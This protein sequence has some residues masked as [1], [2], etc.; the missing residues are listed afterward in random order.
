M[1]T[2]FAARLLALSIVSTGLAAAPNE[3]PQDRWNLADLYPTVAAWNATVTWPSRSA[4]S[5][6]S[7]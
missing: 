6:R 1:M 3:R 7:A 4:A 2:P 5:R